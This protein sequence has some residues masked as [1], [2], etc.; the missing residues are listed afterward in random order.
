MSLLDLI[1]GSEGQEFASQIE[2]KFGVSQGQFSSLLASAAPLIASSLEGNS[3]V[4]NIANKAMENPQQL[5][6]NPAEGGAILQQLFGDNTQ[7]IHN[8]LSESSGISM[9]KIM[10]ILSM[11]APF[12]ISLLGKGDSNGGGIGDLLGNL[13]G[14]KSG[15]NPLGG[16]LGSVLGGG[17]EGASGNPL[18]DVLGQVLGGS[19][20]KKGGL[21]DLLGGFLGK[22]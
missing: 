5:L 9:D 11:V 21:G 6:D 16:L 20:D 3:E 15:D 13:M 14:G 17:K 18:N 8:Q 10:P 19:D 22:K 1:T 12:I 4:S 2:E 7:N